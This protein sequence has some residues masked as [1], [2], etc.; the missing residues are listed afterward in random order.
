MISFLQGIVFDYN[1][2]KLVLNVQGVGF[3]LQVSQAGTFV[4]GESVSLC[5]YLQWNQEQGPLLFGFHNELEKKVFL[6]VISCSGIGPKIALALLSA[7]TP[8]VFLQIIQS[9][10]EKALSGIPGIGAKKAEQM[11][12]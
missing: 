8:S 2:N 9:G 1:G 7:L 12:V 6:L 10:D 5:V 3:D 4:I 11:I